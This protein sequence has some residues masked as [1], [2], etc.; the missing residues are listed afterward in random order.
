MAVKHQ[1][2]LISHA[3]PTPPGAGAQRRPASA[4]A[5]RYSDE[6][7]RDVGL[8]DGSRI[9]GIPTV[10]STGAGGK[11]L[12]SSDKN[13]AGSGLGDEK[14]KNELGTVGSE[15]GGPQEHLPSGDWLTQLVPSAQGA[16][17]PSVPN[18]WL[19]QPVGNGMLQDG[20]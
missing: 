12:V 3:T 14:P 4:R 10:P 20:P 11:E 19:S 1:Q 7:K 6:A 17:A 13:A 9:S 8:S 18:D 15:E 2:I 5:A 16:V